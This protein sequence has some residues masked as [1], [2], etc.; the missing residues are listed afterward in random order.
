M[1]MGTGSRGNPKFA[2][3]L[4]FE[5][6]YSAYPDGNAQIYV[7]IAVRPSTSTEVQFSVGVASGI[8]VSFIS[9]G[10]PDG[11]GNVVIEAQHTPAT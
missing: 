10:N 1:I 2:V 5:S 6:P 9:L 11:T 3:V 4:R 8:G 7:P